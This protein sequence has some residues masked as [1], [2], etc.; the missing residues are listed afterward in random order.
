IVAWSVID[1][2]RIRHEVT[3]LIESSSNF[4][5]EAKLLRDIREQYSQIA[6][7]LPPEIQTLNSNLLVV[8]LYNGTNDVEQFER[9]A[10]ELESWIAKQKAV[11]NQGKLVMIDPQQLTVNVRGLVDKIDRDYDAYRV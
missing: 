2:R 4:V 8:A 9:R 1:T 3:L 7:Q 11:A 6:T 10:G 5:V